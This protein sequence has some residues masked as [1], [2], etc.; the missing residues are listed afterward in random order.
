[1]AGRCSDLIFQTLQNPVGASLLAKASCLSMH[2]S[3]THRIREQAR[4][5]KGFVLPR[6]AQFLYIFRP[7]LIW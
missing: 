4:S 2:L 3:L 6:R 1:L 5:H 7:P